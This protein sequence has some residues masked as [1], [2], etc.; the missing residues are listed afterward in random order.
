MSSIKIK[1]AIGTIKETAPK[2]LSPLS[3][4]LQPPDYY[5]TTTKYY[6]L[7][8]Y[9]GGKYDKL[10]S[11]LHYIEL[12]AQ[13]NDASAFVECF[14][15]GGKCI[16]NIDTIN[17]HF[18]KKIYNE[19]DA[20]MCSLFRMASATNTAKQL[21]K[22][23]NCFDYDK[24]TFEYCKIHR[25]DDNL[26]DLYMACM[27]F[28]LCMMGFNGS[29]RYYS[30][31]HEGDLSYIN[32]I[33]RIAYAPEHLKDVEIIN[34]DY[35]DMMKEYG[36]NSLVVKYLDPPYHPACRNQN[37]L[38]EYQNELTQQQHQEMVG[39]LC[40]SRSWILS[41]YDPAQWGCSDY[42]P[43]EK[44][45]AVKVSI[46]QYMVSVTREGTKYKEEFIWYKI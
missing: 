21:I 22:E 43:L 24:E 15:G 33:N 36:E 6:N 4:L 29:T 35:I 18:K 8:K 25:N 27:V 12:V 30:K 37:A 17:H 9:Y 28:M 46:G 2:V 40:Q 5:G 23:L 42:E 14:G 44:A 10:S 3:Y 16:L 31:F 41:G 45:G 34:G 19:L 26:C 7:V 32:A 13:V 38:Q 20:G 11:I 1:K 39:I